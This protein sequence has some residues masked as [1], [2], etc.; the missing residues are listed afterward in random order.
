M[1]ELAKVFDLKYEY[2]KTKTGKT[3][4]R[5]ATLVIDWNGTLVNEPWEGPYTFMEGA[6]GALRAFLRAG[7]AIK[8]H[9]L[10]LHS[11][12][13]TESAPCDSQARAKTYWQMRDLLDREG[14][15]EIEIE[16]NI[17]KLPCVWMIDDKALHFDGNWGKVTRKVLRG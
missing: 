17:D 9:S 1:G 16:T 15:K 6:C 3:L 8:V 11:K 12:D 7:Y 14:F 13:F 10:V 5:P 4:S 2:T